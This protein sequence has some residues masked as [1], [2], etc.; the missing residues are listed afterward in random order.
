MPAFKRVRTNRVSLRF[1]AA[2]LLFLHV[3]GLGHDRLDQEDLSP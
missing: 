2:G 3:A 1:M